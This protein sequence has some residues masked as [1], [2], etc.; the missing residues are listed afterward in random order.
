MRRGDSNCWGWRVCWVVGGP[1][2]FWGLHFFF[3]E[4]FRFIRFFFLQQNGK[5]VPKEVTFWGGGLGPG[6]NLVTMGKQASVFWVFVTN[7]SFWENW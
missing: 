7:R 2:F 5:C 1:L 6:P 4:R 3:V